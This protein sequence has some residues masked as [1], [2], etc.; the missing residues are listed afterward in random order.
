MGEMTM[1]FPPALRRWIEQRIADG[2]FADE[3]DYFRDLVRRDQDGALPETPEEI[4]WVREQVAIGLASGVCE[5]DAFD[6]LNEIKAKRDSRR[7]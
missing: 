5:R 3:A 1:S 2:R 7:A 6:V 4:A